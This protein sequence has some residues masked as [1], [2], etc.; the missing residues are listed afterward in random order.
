MPGKMGFLQ[1]RLRP[2]LVEVGRQLAAGL[3][4][5]NQERGKSHAGPKVSRGDYFSLNASFLTG[6]AFIIIIFRHQSSD[7]LTFQIKVER[8]F[9]FEFR[10]LNAS[11]AGLESLLDLD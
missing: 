9:R 1:I 2:S 10:N 7:D 6:H 5:I 4:P 11:T 3:A 8:K